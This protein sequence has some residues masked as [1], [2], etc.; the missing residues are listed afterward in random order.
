MIQFEAGKTYATR[1]I[2]DADNILRVTIA[3]RTAKTVTTTEG[4]TFRVSEHNG[5][6]IFAPL[7]R[8]S[9]SPMMRA[10]RLDEKL[11]AKPEDL[12]ADEVE[13]LHSIRGG[14]DVWAYADAK[15]G[16]DIERKRPEL[17]H[18][19][20]A[21]EKPPGEQRQPYYGVIAT[22]EGRAYL[23]AMRCSKARAA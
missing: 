11:P 14:A 13:W 15:V 23:R 4:K 18:I 3:K 1:F 19:C 12:T 22:K 10:D 20:K 5:A 7:G 17:I 2:G 6:E 16:R 21:M 8:Y 9:M